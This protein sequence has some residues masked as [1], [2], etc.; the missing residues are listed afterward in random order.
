MESLTK[1][2][3]LVAATETQFLLRDLVPELLNLLLHSGDL[4]LRG[5]VKT[6]TQI[7]VEEIIVALVYDNEQDYPHYHCGNHNERNQH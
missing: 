6:A 5:T 7:L 2:S 1:F 4:G 3:R